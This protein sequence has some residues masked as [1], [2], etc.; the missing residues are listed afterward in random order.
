M[1]DVTTS[2]RVE[3]VVANEPR[4]GFIPTPPPSPSP[5]K[6]AQTGNR[7]LWEQ[8]S[9]IEDKTA[10][11]EEKYS[12][13]ESLL[14]RVEDRVEATSARTGELASQADLGA[15][16]NRISSLP[17]YGALIFAAIIAAILAAGA[18]YGVMRYGVPGFLPPLA[19][20][21]PMTTGGTPP[22]TAPAGTTR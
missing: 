18:T 4:P 19:T 7:A 15:L 14:L 11:I 6:P 3:P 2:G 8:L 1:S 12:R 17:G 20:A 21:G 16:S 22:A 13:T 10:R 5:E 9:R